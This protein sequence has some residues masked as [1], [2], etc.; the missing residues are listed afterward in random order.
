MRRESGLSIGRLGGGGPGRDD[1]DQSVAG[2]FCRCRDR[3]QTCVEGACG[4]GR[5]TVGHVIA[6]CQPQQWTLYKRKHGEVARSIHYSAARA[7]DLVAK[8]ESFT[9]PDV[10]NGKNGKASFW[11]LLF[12]EVAVA[13]DI[14]VDERAEEK[15]AKYRGLK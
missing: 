7:L 8:T 9:V 2:T 14:R 6:I 5:E 11:D 12:V 3:C 4:N 10:V 13:N 15:R 1:P